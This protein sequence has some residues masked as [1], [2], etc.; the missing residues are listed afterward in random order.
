MQ[1]CTLDRGAGWRRGHRTLFVL[2][3]YVNRNDNVL[4]ETTNKRYCYFSDGEI[5]RIG[6]YQKYNGSDCRC[7]PFLRNATNLFAFAA[8]GAEIC[9]VRTE[10]SG[11]KMGPHVSSCSIGDGRLRPSLKNASPARRGPRREANTSN[12]AYALAAALL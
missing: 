10:R 2:A 5:F 12:I 3:E 9:G 4:E 7:R 1:V 8:R 11:V 6:R